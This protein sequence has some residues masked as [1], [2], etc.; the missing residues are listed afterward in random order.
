FRAD[1]RRARRLAVSHAFHSPHMDEILDDFRE[2]AGSLAYAPPRIEVVSLVTGRI[3]GAE[4]LCAPEYWVRHVRAAVRFLDGVRTLRDL[5]V[6]TCLEVGPTPT[7]TPL[8]ASTLDPPPTLVNT[9]RPDQPES[10]G[11]A[12]ALAHLHTGGIPI[13]WPTRA[14]HLTRLP[15]YPFEHH[16][17][18]LDRPRDATDPAALGLDRIGHPLLD[19]VLQRADGGL[20]VTGRVSVAAQPWLAGHAVGGVVL[21]PGAAIVELVMAVA[22]LVDCGLVDELTLERPVVLDEDV[23][24]Q[25]AVEA[26]GDQGVRRVSLYSRPEAGDGTA[27]DRHAFGAVSAAVDE[28]TPGIWPPPAGAAETDGAALYDQLS[29]RGYEYGPAFRAVERVWHS[30][31]ETF[32]QVRTDEAG[33]FGVHPALLDAVLHPAAVR[34]PAGDPLLPFALSRVSLWPSPSTVL[35]ARIRSAGA[36]RLEVVAVDEA[37]RPVLRVESLALRAVAP[38]QLAATRTSDLLRLDWVPAPDPLEVAEAEPPYTVAHVPDLTGMDP[39]AAAHRVTAWASARCREWL[40]EAGSRLVF[41]TRGAVGVGVVDVAGAA[42]WGLVRC[43]VV[44]HPGRFGLVDTDGG[45]PVEWPAA[46]SELVVRGSAVAVPRLA[47]VGGVSGGPAFP[48]SGVVLVTGGSG[49]LAGLAVRH[50]VGTCGVRRVVLASRRGRDAEG[51]GAL[52]GELESWGTS[53]SVVACDVSDAVAV[54]ELVAA[55]AADGPLGGVVHT[56]GVLDD[57]LLTDLTP[58][59]VDA[60]LRPK[61]DAAWHLHEATR[62]LDLAAFV[63][64]S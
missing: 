50:L 57:A 45:L 64:F 29:L 30:G 12:T 7:L 40:G 62:E 11:V 18:W 46:E 3:A 53:V 19:A 2:V 48:G 38:R 59:R 16:R 8:V 14:S 15:T 51:I 10:H 27:W 31:D 22:R 26:A 56:A 61:L 25:V 63:L 55:I 35:R 28:P 34:E 47:R 17:Y 9:L 58:D 6:D 43:A 13:T 24:L 54:R 60:V 52:V 5:G 37:S 44:E 23:R 41:V 33:G 36:G 1:G 21:L 4:E 39:V 20:V 49:D 32:V 42:V